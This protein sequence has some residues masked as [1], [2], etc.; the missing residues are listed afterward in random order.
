VCALLLPFPPDGFLLALFSRISV[1]ISLDL[2]GCVLLF[3]CSCVC[4]LDCFPVSRL[5]CWPLLIFLN[6]LSVCLLVCCRGSSFPRVVAQECFLLIFIFFGEWLFSRSF[7]LD[8]AG[9][10]L[11]G[12]ASGAESRRRNGSQSGRWIRLSV[13]GSSDWRFR[14]WEIQSAFQIYKERVLLGIE[15]DYWRGVR[16]TLYSGLYLL[17]VFFV[18]LRRVFFFP[19]R[20]LYLVFFP[21]LEVHLLT[22]YSRSHSIIS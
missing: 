10:R 4:D 14:S 3:V 11:T 8:P 17:V 7:F 2:E 18:M 21:W 13:Q 5:H 6:Y 22:S 16:H 15:I 20:T 19:V 9:S 1:S 12:K